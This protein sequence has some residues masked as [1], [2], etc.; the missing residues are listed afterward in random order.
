MKRTIAI[1]TLS[2]SLIS[3]PAKADEHRG[4]D[5]ALGA[6]SGAVVFGPIGAIAG[7]AVGYAAGPSIAH[8]WGF[9]RSHP[10]ARRTK[11]VHEATQAADTR[12]AVQPGPPAPKAASTAPPVQ[13]LEY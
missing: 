4:G 3:S 7:A 13:S 5:A 1:A 10:T 9:R 12:P 8:S 11:P 6:L 2:L